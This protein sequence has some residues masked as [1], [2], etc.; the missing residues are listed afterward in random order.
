MLN[1]IGFR[2][3]RNYTLGEGPYELRSVYRTG[4]H[5]AFR[6]AQLRR[7]TGFHLL[8]CYQASGRHKAS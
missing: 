2:Q 3:G 4:A 8:R 7:V 5:T 6:A 1:R